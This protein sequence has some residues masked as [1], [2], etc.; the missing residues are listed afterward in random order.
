MTNHQSPLSAE[1]ASHKLVDDFKALISD[2]EALIKAS[3]E[4][5]G[6]AMHSV[7][8]KAQQT[9]STAKESLSEAQDV[10]AEKAKEAAQ[11]ADVFVHE[12][13]WQAVG[14][15]AGAGLLIGLLIGRR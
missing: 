12:K 5:G 6:E 8:A 9:L 13:P 14:I 15:A 2:A 7:R 4:H 10:I 11:E 1:H 3:A